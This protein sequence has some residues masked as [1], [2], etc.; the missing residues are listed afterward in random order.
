MKKIIFCPI[1]KSTDVTFDAKLETTYNVCRSCGYK[2]PPGADF[3][4]KIIKELNRVK[5]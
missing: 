5:K 4:H 3:P 1:C 2:S